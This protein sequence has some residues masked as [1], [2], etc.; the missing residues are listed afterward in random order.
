[1]PDATS[2]ST[3]GEVDVRTWKIGD[4]AAATGVTVRTLR[5]FDQIGLLCPA[6]RS[7][8]GHRVYTS[9]DVR[10]L[11]QILAL[12]ELRL[13]LGG[14]ADALNGADLQATIQTQLR[15]VERRLASQHAL[16]RRLLGI[17]ETLR[18]AQR[19]S[20]D[21]LI[22]IMEATMQARHFT[23]GQLTQFQARHRE[24]GHEGFAHRLSGLRDLSAEAGV[25]AE[26]GTE[27]VV[28]L[29]NGDRSALAALYDK[30]GTKGTEAATK[31]FSVL[32]RGTTSREPSPPASQAPRE[33]R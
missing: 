5:H 15:L 26:R 1:M 32:P 20:I 14:I 9:D 31:G 10:R 29:V 11:Y 8:A 22:A 3:F 21:Q 13:P 17:V 2:A 7:A 4:L 30:I 16:R 24:L 25:H 28:E 23:P 33:P 6:Q 27:A 19:P 18:K 12:R